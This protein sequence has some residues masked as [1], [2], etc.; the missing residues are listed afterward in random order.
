MNGLRNGP[1]SDTSKLANQCM[2]EESIKSSPVVVVSLG[3]TSTTL[4]VVVA[5][6]TLCMVRSFDN[7]PF[8]R[9]QQQKHS[10]VCHGSLS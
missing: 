8:S 2:P 10:R 4:A 6:V 3:R 9:A 1:L 7:G 5:V